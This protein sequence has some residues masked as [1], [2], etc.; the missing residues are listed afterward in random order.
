MDSVEES[1]GTLE[2]FCRDTRGS[3]RDSRWILKALGRFGADSIGILC[4]F[5]EDCRG[6][7]QRDSKGILEGS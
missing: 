5:L 1:K 4:G 2:G 3:L 7:A 6:I